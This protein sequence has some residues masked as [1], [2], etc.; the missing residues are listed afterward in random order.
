MLFRSLQVAPQMAQ[1]V[2]RQ[3]GKC[4]GLVGADTTGHLQRRSRNAS[5]GLRQLAVQESPDLDEFEPW[6]L[7]IA[8]QLNPG[9]LLVTRE[10]QLT[11]QL[12]P[13]EPLVVVGR[14]VDQTCSNLLTHRIL[15]AQPAPMNR[16]VA[17]PSRR[18]NRAGKRVALPRNR[19][20]RPS[21]PASREASRGGRR[22]AGATIRGFTEE[23]RC[24]LS[25]RAW[26]RLAGVEMPVASA[27]P[28]SHIP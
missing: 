16:A 1:V 12:S 2:L 15:Q 27:A 17:P 5:K 26:T 20:L 25:G 18:A 11:R 7:L 23:L 19:T 14:G 22:S 24:A 3:E 13:N 8:L 9:V 28:L 4:D 6:T 21:L 10:R